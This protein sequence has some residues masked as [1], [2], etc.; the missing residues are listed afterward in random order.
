MKI[1]IFIADSNGGY[2]VPAVKGGAVS[3]LVEHLVEKNNERQLAEMTVVSY[4]DKE[5]VEK[6]KKYPN[7]IFKWIKPPKIIKKMDD[8]SFFILKTFFK[9]Q[10]ALSFKN[11]WSLIYYIF[12][13]ASFLKSK[14]YDNVVLE[15]N[16]PMAW[17]IKMAKYEGKYFYHFHNV[18]R[19]NAKVK[20]VFEKCTGY[21]CVSDYV[22]KQIES[23]DNPIGPIPK[24]KIKVLY[25]A[26]DMEQFE[27]NCKNRLQIRRKFSIKEKDKVVLFVGRLSEEKGIDKLFKAVKLLNN[28]VKIL[29]VGSYLHGSKEKD[30]YVEYIKKLANELENKVIFT[31][32]ISQKEVNSIYNAADV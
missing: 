1:A 26:V 6:A 3:T 16:I 8:F 21:L 10:K 18:P 25:N 24:S 13:S 7:I 29:V 20:S 14:E 12:K 22:A 15:N 2:P 17:I 23:E 30:K 32:F 5:A 19:I 9:H 4:Y 11:L 28:N 31:G 27:A